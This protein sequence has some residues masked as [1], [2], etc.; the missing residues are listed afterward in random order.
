MIPTE[1]SALLVKGS[2]CLE[3]SRL[4]HDP[5][6]QCRS[7]MHYRR[8]IDGLRALAVLPAIL[9]HAS[10]DWVSGGFAGVDVFFVISGY[11]ITSIILTELDQGCFSIVR[12][13]ERRARRILPALFLVMAV[14][15]PFA[16]MWLLPQDMK[17]FAQSLVAIPLFAPNVLFWQES[18]YFAPV[19]ELKPLLHTWSLAVEEQYYLLFPPLMLLAWR[20]G[21]RWIP[22]MLAATALLS[23]ASAHWMLRVDPT[24]AYF[25]LPSRAWELLVGAVLAAGLFRHPPMRPEGLRAELGGAAGLLLLLIAY[26]SYDTSTPF[27]GIA[28]LMPTLGAALIILCASSRTWVGRMLGWRPLVGLGLIS[29][30]AYLWHQPLFALARHRSLFEPSSTLLIALVL[31]TLGLATLSWRFVETPFRN[32][33]AISNRAV[34]GFAVAGTALFVS[35]GM[36]GYLSDGAYRSGEKIEQVQSLER[37]T[38]INA[39]IRLDCDH[40]LEWSTQCRTSE[41]PEVM[42]WGDSFAMHL[43]P[44]LL[45]SNP[46][47]KLVQATLSRCG[48]FLGIAPVL[49]DSSST[50]RET[51]MRGNDA[52]LDVVRQTPSI[53]YVVMS[54][55]FDQ[56]VGDTAKV[57]NRDGTVLAGR[58]VAE[59]AMLHTLDELTRLGKIPV[60]FSPTPRTGEDFGQCLKKA[61][62]LGKDLAVCDVDAARAARLHAPVRQFLA[63]LAKDYPVIWLDDALCSGTTCQASVNGTFIYRDQGHLSVEGSAYLGK[64]MDFYGRIARLNP[65]ASPVQTEQ[66]AASAAGCCAPTAQVETG[67]AR[68]QP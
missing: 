57:I 34:L 65:Q 6:S 58:A 17:D 25:L 26:F 56:Y 1:H 66:A 47:L 39:G 41:S 63:T 18:G 2:S 62:M 67:H 38:V 44:G 23:L 10:K 11:L 3:A 53:K 43:A 20:L 15:L 31:A 52:A 5:S 14:S 48:P 60:L 8:E 28:A 33:Q 12:F 16:S 50:W 24:A 49:P 54:S 32:K 21:R 7:P 30:S 42:L 35:V 36:A 46:A 55:P 37:R 40:A 13:Y 51:C 45:A 29:Y 22:A 68:L 59:A 4:A 64:T 61:T 19:A 9:F 27:P